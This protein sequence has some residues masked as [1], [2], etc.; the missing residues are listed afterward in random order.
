MVGAK[1]AP[2]Q[3]S[4]TSSD[5]TELAT[6]APVQGATGTPGVWRPLLL[7]LLVAAAALLGLSAV[8]AASLLTGLDGAS[9]QPRTPASSVSSVGSSG[10]PQLPSEAPVTAA[11]APAASSSAA[12]GCGGLLADGRV[13]LNRA[14]RDDLRKLP[15]IGAKR[16]EAILALRTRL[17]RFRRTSDL[18]RVKGIGPKFMQRNQARLLLDAPAGSCPTPEATAKTTDPSSPARQ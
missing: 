4:V 6:V 9:A 1:D 10:P 15:G 7:R 14:E 3:S 11:S 16:A 12:P 8:G 5:V 13:V 17:G 18:L 2:T